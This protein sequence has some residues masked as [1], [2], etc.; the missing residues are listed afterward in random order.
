[1]RGE[2]IKIHPLKYGKD[3]NA[4]HRVEFDIWD[5][6]KKKTTWAKTD[7]VEGYRNFKRWVRFLKVGTRLKGLELKREGEINA[8]CWP[9]LFEQKRLG[10]WEKLP[11][12]N[13]AWIEDSQAEEM[14][15]MN[16]IKLKQPKLI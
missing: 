14:R 4:Y 15:R 3:G 12:G 5:K 6:D 11:D 9:E 7:L 1:M 2:I 13:M 10:H 8:D 16:K